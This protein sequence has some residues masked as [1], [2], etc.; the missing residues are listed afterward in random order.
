MGN[1]RQHI[2]QLNVERT[3][4]PL[5][6]PAN[7]HWCYS[8]PPPV[9][10]YHQSIHDYSL[11]KALDAD[12]DVLVNQLRHSADTSPLGQPEDIYFCNIN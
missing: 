5:E 11:Y 4:L 6:G 9:L 3:A 1:R 12:F 8:L 2:D 10:H 7:V